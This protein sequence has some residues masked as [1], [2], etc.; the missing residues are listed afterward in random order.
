VGG[1]VLLTADH[2]NAELMANADGSVHTA[3]TLNPVPFILID[4]RRRA[5]RLRPG[6]LADIAPTLLD[7]MGID[8]PPE[9]TGESLLQP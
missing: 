1:A 6:S 7:L 9:M 5:A 8:R 2:G 3:H 4:D